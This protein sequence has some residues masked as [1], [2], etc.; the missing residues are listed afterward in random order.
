MLVEFRDSEI[1]GQGKRSS[2]LTPACRPG[3]PGNCIGKLREYKQKG[4]DFG[5]FFCYQHR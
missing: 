3:H 4:F 2:G 1:A 5:S